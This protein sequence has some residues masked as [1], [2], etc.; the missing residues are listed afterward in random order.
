MQRAPG[1]PPQ[2]LRPAPAACS[3]TVVSAGPGTLLLLCR[4]RPPLGIVCCCLESM[5][6]CCDVCLLQRLELGSI[7][8]QHAPQSGLQCM[9]ARCR[10]TAHL[11]QRVQLICGRKLA[12]G[13][14][15]VGLQAGLRMLLAG[16]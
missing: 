6:A 9:Q 11:E 15:V 14:V 2:R 7:S 10:S 8:L 13:G 1:A 12:K 5:H 3:L 4:A 16:L